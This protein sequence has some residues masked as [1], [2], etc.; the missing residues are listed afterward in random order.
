MSKEVRQL[1]YLILKRGF[2]PNHVKYSDECIEII[3]RLA[4]FRK[5]GFQYDGEFTDISFRLEPQ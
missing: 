2:K 3:F 4:G 5:Y 1:Y